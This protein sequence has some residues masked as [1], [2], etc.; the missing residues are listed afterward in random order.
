MIVLPKAADLLD[1]L[2]REALL[3]FVIVLTMDLDQ[4]KIE[5]LL[6]VAPFK[7]G[8]TNYLPF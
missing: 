3:N 4:V 7:P 2:R 6:L 1:C 8:L 5:L